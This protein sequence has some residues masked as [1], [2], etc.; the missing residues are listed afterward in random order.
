MKRLIAVAT[1]CFLLVSCGPPEDGYGTYELDDGS[2]Y[3]GEWKDSRWH[4]QG[5]HTS[6]DGAKYV[7]AFKE[8]KMHGQGVATRPDGVKYA[9]EWKDNKRHGQGTWTYPDGGKHVGEFKNGYGWRTISYNKGG[10]VIQ[11]R[12]D[13]LVDLSCDVKRTSV[14][15]TGF[16][17]NQHHVVT[18]AHVVACCKAVTIHDLESCSD[19]SEA[20]VVATE[21]KS[22][23]GLLRLD[24]PLQHHATLR[25]GKALQ[26]GDGV[27]TYD[28]RPKVDDCPQYVVEQG[29]VTELN[30]MPDDSRLMEHDSPINPGS[31]GGPVLDVSGHIVG[32]S[33]IGIRGLNSDSRSA[34]SNAIKSNLLDAFLK[35]NRVEYK[36]APSTEKLS[37][38]E[39][40]ARSEKFTVIVICFR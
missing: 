6:P 40:K 14:V 12:V 29:K 23:L 11:R 9:G 36:T 17:V 4:G 34:R 20:T 24:K 2:K 35:S 7:G 18:S 13:G 8:G 30:W 26:L 27:S 22:D 33:A 1:L 37:Q 31:S 10:E 21:Q 15:G 16:V 25:S 32:V 19:G 5:T 3:V 38:S 28:R 39:I